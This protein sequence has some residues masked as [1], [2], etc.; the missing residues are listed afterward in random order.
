VAGALRSVVS[1]IVLIAN[2][3]DAH[4]WLPGARVV[5]DAR[6]ERASV[7]GIHT[8]LTAAAGEPVLVVAWDMPFVSAPLLA[9]LR[10]RLRPGLDAVVPEGTDGLEPFCAVYAPSALAAID[11]AIE[12]HELRLGDVLASFG[13][14]DRVPAAE[15]ARFGPPETLFF[16]VNDRADLARAERMARGG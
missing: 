7:V 6:A 5:R 3:A 4:D 8:A 2:A 16:N 11:A 10:D 14:V 9:I 1:D 15:V 13:A 12:R